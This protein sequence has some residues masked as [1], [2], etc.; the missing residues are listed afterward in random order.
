MYDMFLFITKMYYIRNNSNDL[1]KYSVSLKVD[2]IDAG[3]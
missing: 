2:N 1:T 3:K